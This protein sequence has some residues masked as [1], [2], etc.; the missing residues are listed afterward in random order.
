MFEFFTE[1]SVIVFVYSVVSSLD[2][3]EEKIALLF[4]CLMTKRKTSYVFFAAE[5]ASG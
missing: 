4:T 5:N 2:K 1:I 3:V